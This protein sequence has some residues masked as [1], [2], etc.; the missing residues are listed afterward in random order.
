MRFRHI[1]RVRALAVLFMVEVH[2]AAI[3]PPEGVTVGHPAAFVAA[4]FGGMAAPLFVTISGWGM[5]GSARRRMQE[6]HS[7]SQ[8][9]YWIL[10]RVILLFICQLLVNLLLNVERGGRFEWQTPGVLTLLAI[11]ALLS[12][13]IVRTTITQRS[14]ALLILCVSP[15]LL[16]G[17][18]GSEMTWFQRVDSNGIEEWL[19]RL[20]WNGTYPAAPWLFFVILGTI[21]HDFGADTKSREKGVVMGLFVTAVTLAI[22]VLEGEAWALTSGEALL[23]FFPASI[24]FLV[25]S[26]TMVVLMMRLLEGDE[27]R[28][29]QP[30]LGDRISFLE[31]AGRLSLTI[32][33]SHFAVLGIVAATMDGEPRLGIFP[34]FAATIGHTLVWVPLAYLHE[35]HIPGISLEGLLKSLSREGSL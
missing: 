28:G 7:G 3:I 5:Y 19:A 1:D 35:R 32:Y 29:G 9:A 27:A 12:P 21:L 25:V 24:P 11:A 13:I 6:G 17:V 10:P 18:S 14:L 26:G 16:S 20:L 31:P 33:V 34:A 4:A 22:A 2:T 30:S 15:L 23:T 8:W